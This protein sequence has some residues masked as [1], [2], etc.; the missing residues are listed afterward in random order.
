LLAKDQA[1]IEAQEA[2]RAA[3]ELKKSQEKEKKALD[4]E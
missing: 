2:T 4:E 3:R 1:D